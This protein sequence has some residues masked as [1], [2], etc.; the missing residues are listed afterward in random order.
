MRQLAQKRRETP[1]TD[2]GQLPAAEEIPASDVSRPKSDADVMS[3]PD[4]KQT[5]SEAVVGRIKDSELTTA[6]GVKADV[7]EHLKEP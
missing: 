6:F 5:S 4:P 3:A 1:E 2:L 7:S